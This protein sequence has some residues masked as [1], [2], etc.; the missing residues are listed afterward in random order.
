MANA[1]KKITLADRFKKSVE[2][3]KG[4]PVGNLYFGVDLR[5]CDQCEYKN[6]P[7]TRDKLLI[8]AGTRA[9]YMNYSGKIDIPDGFEEECKL[10]EF[11]TKVVDDY[12]E[13]DWGNFDLYLEAKLIEQ[14]GG[15]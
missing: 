7:E 9:A 2:A 5:R 13:L 6:I 3:F 15:E 10:A 12:I 14:Y 1:I 4:T 11:L 8:T